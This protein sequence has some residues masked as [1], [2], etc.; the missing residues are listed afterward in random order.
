[1][2]SR[3]HHTWAEPK[4]L[5]CKILVLQNDDLIEWR[6]PCSE[7]LPEVGIIWFHW[8]LFPSLATGGKTPRTG[9][10]RGSRCSLFTP[11]RHT[12]VFDYK[13]RSSSSVAAID[14]LVRA[15]WVLLKVTASFV[16]VAL[17]AARLVSGKRC[18]HNL[19]LSLSF[20]LHN[21]YK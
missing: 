1:M 15:T 7:S 8:V 5:S 12:V 16:T 11:H 4:R 17:N 21:R 6:L 13:I 2:T 18:N 19:F 9:S 10:E 14:M 20:F 3:P